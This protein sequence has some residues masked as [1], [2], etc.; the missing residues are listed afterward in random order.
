VVEEEVE[1]EADSL[2]KNSPIV[3]IV[4]CA[5][6]YQHYY[7]LPRPRLLKIPIEDQAVMTLAVV[8]IVILD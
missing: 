4:N 2:Y 3:F 6:V 8:K 1:G 7:F 5:M